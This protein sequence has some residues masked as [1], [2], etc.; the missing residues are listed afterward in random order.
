MKK[1]AGVVLGLTAC[2]VLAG[3][4]D[5]EQTLTLNKDMSGKTGFSMG[6]D[7]EPFVLF[8]LQ[9]QREMSGQKG[10]LTQAEIDKA[11]QEFLASRKTEMTESAEVQKAEVEKSLPPGVKLLD[12]KLEDQGLKM[13]ARFTFGFDDVA[14]LAQVKLPSK[15]E[16]GPGASN[17][18]SEPFSNLQV[19]DEGSTLLLTN[20]A[21]N[22]AE[23]QKAQTEGMDISPEMEKQMKDAFKGLRY[24]FKVESPFEV[25]ESNATRR[26]GRT[27]I[28]EYDLAAFE[29]MT[30][31]QAAEGI[32]VRFKK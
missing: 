25:V 31:E 27:L 10:E 11:K 32:R 8:M 20:K 23:A 6:V 13:K 21:D 24:T 17:P 5:V 9:M 3:C 2:L 16:G 22:P 1:I 30:P 19:K 12:S 26:E 28:W 4:F 29:K 7:M 15:G 18:Y 14:K